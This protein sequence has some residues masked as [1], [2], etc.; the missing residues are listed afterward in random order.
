MKINI[1]YFFFAG[2][3]LSSC[4]TKKTIHLNTKASL[5]QGDQL[6]ENPL[7]LHPFTTI[8]YPK[9]SLM[10]TLYGNDVAFDYALKNSNG[11][12]PAGSILYEVTWQEQPDTQW[13][14][15]KIPK[16][17]I[18]VERIQFLTKDL[19]HYSKYEDTPLKSVLESGHTSRADWI[20]TQRPAIIP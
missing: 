1:L 14:G 15:A 18:V 4:H 5:H 8:I 3:L 13:F 16:K 20:L 10:S 2:I 11:K 7:S 9:D 19:Q 17:I 12:Y 6:P